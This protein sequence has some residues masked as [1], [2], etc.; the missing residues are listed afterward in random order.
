MASVSVVRRCSVCGRPSHG[1]PLA[2]WRRA[3]AGVQGVLL[4][5]VERRAK[6]PNGRRL[7][8]E[9][10]ARARGS[11]WPTAAGARRHGDET[12]RPSR[13][14]SGNTPQSDTGTGGPDLC[15]RARMGDHRLGRAPPLLGDH[16]LAFV[17]ETVRSRQGHLAAFRAVWLEVRDQA[18]TGRRTAGMGRP[19]TALARAADLGCRGRRLREAPV[20][21]TGSEGGGGRGGTA[22]QGCGFAVCPKMRFEKGPR[23]TPEIWNGS[24][25]PCEARGSTR[26]L[27]DGRG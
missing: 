15:L 13:R 9:C 17:G 6:S 26:R 27:A 8:A 22:P 10:R 11:E 16:R 14:G 19:A 5:P 25:Q 21:E 3:E 12:L 1:G 18:R 2:L 20:L 24:H 7:S 4:F 23:S